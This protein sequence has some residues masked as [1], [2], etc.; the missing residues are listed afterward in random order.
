MQL[1]TKYRA[2]LEAGKLLPDARQA[3]CVDLLSQL[4]DGLAHYQVAS[5]KYTHEAANY[6]VRHD[7]AS[8]QHP[9]VSFS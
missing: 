2:L 5:E 6:E 8:D 1:A 9:T 4:C 7:M 3:S